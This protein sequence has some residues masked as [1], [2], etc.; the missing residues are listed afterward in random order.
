MDALDVLPALLEVVDEGV[1][2][3][4][5]VALDVFRLVGDLAD[6]VVE[7]EDLLE[8]DTDGVLHVVDLGDEVVGRLQRHWLAA[9]L[10]QRWAEGLD[11][12]LD[13]GLGAEDDVVLL[14]PSLDWSGLG[15]VESA[16]ELVERE[17]LDV[18][19][20]ATV[21][22]VGVRE[23]QDLRV[24]LRE[25]REDQWLVETRVLLRVVVLQTDLELEGLVE[26]VLLRAAR[27]SRIL[28][29]TAGVE[30]AGLLR[31]TREVV[32]AL[33]TVR[34]LLQVADRLVQLLSV[35]AL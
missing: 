21:A 34:I 32:A 19:S 26:L 14:G 28:H 17:E 1:D 2:G 24:G 13:L 31:D 9:D 15:L 25:V 22:V 12:V 4:D 35:H 8:L 27:W 6:W 7:A 10:G 11:D 3:E 5:D 23:D 16:R 33:L 30:D 20:L 18:G 29:D